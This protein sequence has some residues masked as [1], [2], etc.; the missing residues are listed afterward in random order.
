MYQND[1][2]KRP[3][4]YGN[5][6]YRNGGSFADRGKQVLT[7]LAKGPGIKIGAD[8][9]GQGISAAVN[10][11]ITVT[12]TLPN[13]NLQM[14]DGGITT[15]SGDVVEP[16][17]TA[18]DAQSYGAAVMGA[19]NLW[20]TLSDKNA[21]G[22][23]KAVGG[24]AAGTQIASAIPGMEALGPVGT[25]LNVG[26]GGYKILGS[27]AS[28]KQK[29]AATR[30]LAE[31]TGAGI[32]TAGIS[33]VVQL[34]DQKLLGG[35]INKLRGKYDKVMNSPVGMA[36]NPG[37]YIA[38]KAMEKGFG[39]L[40]KFTGSGKSEDQ[41]QRDK[42]RA[43]L[44][45]SG[46]LGD[47]GAEDWN[48]ENADGSTYDIGKDG[49]AKRDNG[50][51]YAEVDTKTQGNAIGAVNPLAYLI[52]GG[53]E[54]LA[55]NFAGYLTNSTTV[56]AGGKDA[57]VANANALARYKAAGYD[58]AEKAIAGIDD[59][60]KAGKIDAAKAAAFKGG[61]NT[62]FGAVPKP[63]ATTTQPQQAAQRPQR[64]A[65]RR[66]TK[67]YQR[68]TY[69]PNVYAPSVASPSASAYGD[70][71]AQALANTYTNNQDY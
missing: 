54:K 64:S 30:R 67:T 22:T 55:T 33:N 68:Q 65:P 52:T 70:E 8:L 43:S 3:Q 28:A 66:S 51:G 2:A 45:S 71:F 19:I 47:P 35:K 60:L 16:G 61:I 63:A 25:A 12:G 23:D 57:A 48:I 50:M 15:P 32:A 38:N 40:D 9:V 29:A 1:P 58:T 4:G 20:R 56:G 27:D 13:G 14:N 42:I 10:P 11:A 46:F 17:S 59:M 62:V 31:D 6:T 7:D 44:K 36:I 34:A 18:K 49:G 39:M 53:N 37:G 21:S 26:Y 41:Q 5:K 69:A 24:I